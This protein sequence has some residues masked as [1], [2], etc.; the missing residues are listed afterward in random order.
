MLACEEQPLE[1]GNQNGGVVRLGDSVR[2]A[3][4]S[5]TPAVHSL[6]THLEQKEYPAPRVRGMDESGREVLTFISG[7]AVHPHNLH[8]L[9][10]SQAMHEVGALI[11]SYHAAQA[12]FVA[13]ADAEWRDEGRDPVGPSEVL[14][15][16]D[17]APWN[18][19]AGPDGWT[20][21]DWDLA[22]PGRRVWDVAWAL[23]SFVGL[24][25]ES[26]RSDWETVERIAAFCDGARVPVGERELLLA[27]VVERT[28]DHARLLRA[29]A[30]AGEPL[31]PRLVAEGHADRWSAGAAHV[32]SRLATW[33]RLSE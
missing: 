12:D 32:R 9:N 25:P 24:W 27:T 21:I 19:I 16:N 3:A 31:Y 18:L 7:D 28:Q 15:H 14:A 8:L 22:A 13:P 11:A 26:E 30:T 29:R 1:G 17:L 4:G 6:L 10:T 20:F 5:W 23:H 33:V 2:R